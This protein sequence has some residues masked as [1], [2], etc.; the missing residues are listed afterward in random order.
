[1]GLSG[2]CEVSFL[3]NYMFVIWRSFLGLKVIKHIC[4]WPILGRNTKQHE[5]VPRNMGNAELTNEGRY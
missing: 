5:S 2:I 3:L 1:M 4:Y